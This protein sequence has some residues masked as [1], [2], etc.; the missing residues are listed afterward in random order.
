MKSFVFLALLGLSLQVAAQL[1][2]NPVLLQKPWPA[3]WIGMPGESGRTYGVYHFRTALNLSAKPA[4]YL[5]HV[6]AD[7]RYRLFVNGQPVSSGPARGDL[8][9]WI[10]ESVDLAPYLQPGR[11][12]LAAVVWNAAEHA[13]V[14]Q[15][16]HSTAFLMQG[17]TE[18]E[19][20]VNTGVKNSGW[21]GLKNEAYTPCSTDNGPRLWTYMVVGPGDR[22]DAARYPWGWEQPGFNDDFWKP[23]VKIKEAVP[24]G[25][26]TDNVWTL[27]PRTIP[28]ME[29]TPQ[30]IP[31]LR[32]A[33]GMSATG[34]FLTGTQP[35]TIP[36]NSKVELLLDQTFETTGYPELTV[37]G[38]K[39]ATVRLT[40]A[41]ALVDQQRKK[42]HR[43]AIEGRV[44][45]GNFDEFLP[46]GGTAR[47]FRPL[48]LRTW[49]Y[50]Q[51]DVETK[52]EPLILN[53]LTGTFSAY[54]LK[55]KARFSSDDRQI[56]DIWNVGWRTARL[57]ANETYYDCPY[58]EQLQ[59]VGDTRI[60]A[61]ISLYVAGDDRLVRKAIHDFQISRVS[62]GL[63]QSRY[64]ANRYQ[65]IPPFSLYWCS[66]V[67]DYWMHRRDDA[68][69]KPY[70]MGIRNV[71][72]WYERHV[73]ANRNMLGP[74][75]W[76]NFEDWNRAWRNGVPGGAT[77]GNSA[78]VTLHLVYTLNQ[79]AELFTGFGDAAQA[80]RY[81]Q[82]AQ[83]LAAGTMRACFDPKRGVLADSPEKKAFSQHA[84][85][86]GVLSGAV[87]VPQ[88]RAVMERVLADDSL[89][90]VTF[91]Y[92][93]Y[94]NQALKKAGMAN[95]Y[96]GQLKPWRDMLAIGLT[97]F[98]ENP[99]P[100]R[101]DCHAWS[102]SPN[103]DLLATVCG[104]T[105]DAPGFAK[106]RIAPALGELQ[107]VDAAMPHPAGEILVKL[108]RTVVNGITADITLP[109]GLTGR[110]VWNGREVPLKAGKQQI[111]L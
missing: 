31:S 88:Q 44:L 101:S 103:Y 34:D 65:L 104:I 32:R 83:R 50:L 62:D 28:P 18:A 12:V 15:M 10:F 20:A 95:Q 57:C 8:N 86:L 27:V 53:D 30:R 48:W 91:Y 25:Q 108:T 6:S 63:T 7:N 97:T 99:E 92:R 98:A 85:I 109:A 59:Y 55:E 67:Y 75:P 40:Y 13:P 56:A 37:S 58:Y 43:D 77:D 70:L 82:L 100:T 89:S 78:V 23:A 24:E 66:M 94:L 93:F 47:R 3:A 45:L 4:R 69:V 60:Q 49:R 35:L 111:K 16:S 11:N 14:A 42:G 64:P 26:G 110:F 54:P 68:F 41:E 38:G 1:S 52:G 73:D 102:A 79:M 2:V 87:P 39:G 21:K 72:D 74:M 33:R 105:P 107:T 9:H 5:V 61:L 22:V 96:V 80:A 29:E 106:V 19:A 51:L 36:P 81:R 71:L 46:D 17:D 84:S 76:W 90:Q